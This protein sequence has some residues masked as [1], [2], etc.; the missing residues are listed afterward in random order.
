MAIHGK[1]GNAN[2]GDFEPCPAGPQRLVAVDVV[3]KGM[4][5]SI[6]SGKPKTQH[7]I[8]IRWQSEKLTKDGKPALLIQQFTLS[9]FVK[10]NL[11]KTLESWRGKPFESDEAAEAFDIE[12]VIGANGYGNVIHVK[13]GTETYANL[14]SIMPLPDGMA[15][16]KPEGYERVCNRPGY[17]PPAVPESVPA[18]DDDDFHSRDINDDFAPVEAPDEDSIPF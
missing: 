16:L 18:S 7:K 6:W 14:A 1:A 15:K 12:K 13:K 11:R 5:T 9:M 8:Q 4:V 2:S 17:V 10:A 3:D